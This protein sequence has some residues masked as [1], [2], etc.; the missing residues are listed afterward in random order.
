MFLGMTTENLLDED[1]LDEIPKNDLRRLHILCHFP[2]FAHSSHTKIN[3]TAFCRAETELR[4]D[5][6]LSRNG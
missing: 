2:C 4:I 3:T 6:P 5:P 1:V